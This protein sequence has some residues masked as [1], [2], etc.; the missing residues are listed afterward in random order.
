MSEPIQFSLDPRC[1]WCWQTSKWVR[2]LEA[3]GTVDV[4][5]G[6]FSLELQNFDKPLDEFDGTRAVSGPALRTLVALREGDGNLAAGR[7]YAALGERYFDGEEDLTDDTVR[8]ALVDASLDTAWLDKAMG[9]ESTWATVVAEHREL[10][11]ETRSFGVPTIRLDGG[12]GPAI[13]GPVISNEPASVDEATRLWEHVTW[14]VRYENFSEL[15]RDRTIQP[16]LARVRTMI[17][18]RAAEQASK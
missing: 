3:A 7:F 1:P 4:R 12:R 18:K 17:A 10:T 5:W 6:T 8:A 13:F 16:D 14:L 11:E 9:D 2:Q 15:K